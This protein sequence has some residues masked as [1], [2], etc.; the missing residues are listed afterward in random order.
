LER[1]P[2]ASITVGR[3]SV[4]PRKQVSR[5]RSGRALHIAI[6]STQRT[7]TDRADDP[8]SSRRAG[9]T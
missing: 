2:S 9:R 7:G 3:S 1:N 6:T 4:I 5:P 8:G